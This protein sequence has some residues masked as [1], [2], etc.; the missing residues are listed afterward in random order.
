LN[1]IGLE[2][3]GLQNIHGLATGTV[4]T[5]VKTADLRVSG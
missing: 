2:F 5:R 3:Y 1:V 4:A